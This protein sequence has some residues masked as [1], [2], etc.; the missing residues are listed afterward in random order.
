MIVCPPFSMRFVYFDPKPNRVIVCARL[1]LARFRKE[2]YVRQKKEEKKVSQVLF[3][4]GPWPLA[5]TQG[6]INFQ[7]KSAFWV[8]RAKR[9]ELSRHNLIVLD[10]VF[11]DALCG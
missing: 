7:T 9:N 10:V 8:Y 2:T 5:G 11:I 6:P 4:Y 3:Q 1:R